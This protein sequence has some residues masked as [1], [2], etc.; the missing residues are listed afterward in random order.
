MVGDDARREL[1]ELLGL[2]VRLQSAL[3]GH[4][5]PVDAL[6]A[7]D[8]LIQDLHD[9]LIAPA[10]LDEGDLRA[11]FDEI[12]ELFFSMNGASGSATTRAFRADY[13]SRATSD[14]LARL[15]AELRALRQRCRSSGD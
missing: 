5:A 1:Q 10:T 6:A 13:V 14:A 2:L 7:L 8:A 9:F 4:G 11:V 12:D 3:R 15:H